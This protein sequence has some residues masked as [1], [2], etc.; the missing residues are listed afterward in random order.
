[1]ITKEQAIGEIE[2]HYGSCQR[3]HGPKGGVTMHQIV[4]KRNGQTKTWVRNPE[5][6]RVPIKRGL[7]EYGYIT[8][9][10][11]HEFHVGTH[12]QCFIE[13]VDSLYHRPWF[14]SYNNSFSYED[15]HGE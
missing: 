5:E 13:D 12:D 8:H 2:F 15:I 10:N 6:F 3:R 7:R 14:D 4:F 1:M 9:T 11:A